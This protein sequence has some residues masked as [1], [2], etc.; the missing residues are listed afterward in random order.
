MNNFVNAINAINGRVWLGCL[1]VLAMLL[2]HLR[3]RKVTPTGSLLDSINGIHVAILGFVLCLCGIGMALSGHEGF[4]DKVFLSGASFIGGVGVGRIMTGK[5]DP[6]A[7]DAPQ[8]PN[9]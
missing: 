9:A 2:L 6:K 8:V 1:V 5:S 4:G 3:Y 7:P